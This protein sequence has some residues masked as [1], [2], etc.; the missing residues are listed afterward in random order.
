M[1]Q[2][3]PGIPQTNLRE[4]G[5][6]IL[7][8][9]LQGAV[10]FVRV[11]LALPPLA[12]LALREHEEHLGGVLLVPGKEQRYPH[13]HGECGKHAPNRIRVDVPLGVE[14][15]ALDDQ[16]R[17][18]D[19]LGHLLDLPEEVAV[20]ERVDKVPGG[21]ALDE[22]PVP[23][24][25][26]P[27]R[28]P[29]DTDRR[30]EIREDL[31]DFGGRLAVIDNNHLESWGV[32]SSMLACSTVT[33]GDD[34]MPPIVRMLLCII[35]SFAWLTWRNTSSEVPFVT[36]TTTRPAPDLPVRPLRW[37]DRISEGTAS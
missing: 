9:L 19:R 12:L 14:V 7:L 26:V 2:Q 28:Q 15:P 18:R 17:A 23:D 11:D 5:D 33:G 25:I 29:L 30:P 4:R 8:L 36:I 6:D 22:D 1:R 21:L 3:Q 37:M 16:H 27:V 34:A 20:D 24:G 31:H 13:I 10:R 35:F 32:N